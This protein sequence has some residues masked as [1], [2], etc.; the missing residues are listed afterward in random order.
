[1]FV[2]E[3]TKRDVFVSAGN[4]YDALIC[5]LCEFYGRRVFVC[6]FANLR[7]EMCLYL[8]VI[9]IGDRDDKREW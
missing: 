5:S 2:R 8:L 4:L 1:M 7:S 6:F 3:S 9:S